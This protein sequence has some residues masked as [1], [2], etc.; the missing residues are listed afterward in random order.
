MVS[1]DGETVDPI[2]ANVSYYSE[3]LQIF[4]ELYRSLEH[5][6]LAYC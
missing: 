1:M 3:K 4:D 2:P 5:M 6:F